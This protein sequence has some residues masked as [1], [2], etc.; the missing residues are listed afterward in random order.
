MPWV[1]MTVTVADPDF[2]FLSSIGKNC[3]TNGD[4][5]QLDLESHVRWIQEG[6]IAEPLINDLQPP[7]SELQA[8]S[9]SHRLKV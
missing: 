6:F 3:V 8:K 7:K 2:N 5:A 4:R 1:T 9:R